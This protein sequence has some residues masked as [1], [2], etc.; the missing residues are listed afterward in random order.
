[1]KTLLLIA[2]GAAL[3][4]LVVSLVIFF[5]LIFAKKNRITYIEES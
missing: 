2:F 1:M 5:N 4:G 3:I